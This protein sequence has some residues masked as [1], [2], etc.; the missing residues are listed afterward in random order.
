MTS[1]EEHQHHCD[2]VE[3]LSVRG[4]P[5]SGKSLL[6]SNIK[7]VIPLE[8]SMLVRNRRSLM[9]FH[10]VRISPLMYDEL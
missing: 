5:M 7:E 8:F 4:V 6:A 2:S 9:Y 10:C 1:A 3:Q